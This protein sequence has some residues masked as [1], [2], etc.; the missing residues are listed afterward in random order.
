MNKKRKGSR[1]EHKSKRLL[2]AAGYYVM[3]ASAS[4]G[5]FD[6]IAV[7]GE[8]ILLVQVKS[9]RWPPRIEIERLRNCPAPPQ[10]QKIVHRW[11]DGTRM[12]DVLQV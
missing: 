2:E 7:S 5:I 4:L 10:C 1:N 8:A 9:N 3:R 6:L 12:P 11:R